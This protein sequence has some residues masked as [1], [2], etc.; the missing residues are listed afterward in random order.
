MT[1]IAIHFKIQANGPLYRRILN[2]LI[3]MCQRK[4]KRVF[5]NLGKILHIT[6]E[7]ARDAKYL[8]FCLL[9]VIFY[10]DIVRNAELEWIWHLQEVVLWRA[11]SMRATFSVFQA[12]MMGPGSFCLQQRPLQ[13]DCIHYN[14]ISVRNKLPSI[15]FSP[16]LFIN[17]KRKTVEKFK[18]TQ[19][20]VC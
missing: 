14:L 18:G 2:H 15:V 20:R 16:C 7:V 6:L 9:E 4:V 1:F 11:V 12:W 10:V 5:S 3:K 19:N 17:N 13:R 8:Y